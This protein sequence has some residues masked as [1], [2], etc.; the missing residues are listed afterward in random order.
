MFG[1]P[2]GRFGALAACTSAAKDSRSGIRKNSGCAS[3]GANSCQSGY[4][5]M[6]TRE[7]SERI[8]DVGVEI[9]ILSIPDYGKQLLDLTQTGREKET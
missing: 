1:F 7:L 8:H 6:V 9:Q 2:A 5:S 4:D 3:S